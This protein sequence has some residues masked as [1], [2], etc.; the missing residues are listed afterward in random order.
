MPQTQ[1]SAADRHW[2][3]T[4]FSVLRPRFRDLYMIHGYHLNP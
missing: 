1:A 3:T 2:L 4:L